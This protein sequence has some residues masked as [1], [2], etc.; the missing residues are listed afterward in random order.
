MLRYQSNV[1]TAIF[2]AD[3]R[4][5][6]SHWWRTVPSGGNVE[7]GDPWGCRELLQVEGEKSRGR[8]YSSEHVPCGAEEL[9]RGVGFRLEPTA[10]V[11]AAVVAGPRFRK[12]TQER[13]RSQ[14]SKV[15]LSGGKA[16][17]MQTR[18]HGEN[19]KGWEGLG[20]VSQGRDGCG[21]VTRHVDGNAHRCNKFAICTYI[22]RI[23][24]VM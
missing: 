2:L 23:I 1:P 22:E 4:N 10:E 20:R 17:W 14:V 3:V 7:C 13:H 12:A 5:V 21:A 19:G 15:P 6:G 24:A 18:Q 9:G 8:W 16:G 11:G